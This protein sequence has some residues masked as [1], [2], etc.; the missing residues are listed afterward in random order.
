MELPLKRGEVFHISV[1]KLFV[2]VSLVTYLSN[3]NLTWLY[4]FTKQMTCWPD[5]FQLSRFNLQI[6]KLIMFEASSCNFWGCE[7]CFICEWWVPY[8]M[9]RLYLYLFLGLCLLKTR[10]KHH[11]WT[12]IGLMSWNFSVSRHRESLL[13]AECC[14]NF[15]LCVAKL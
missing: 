6:M 8:W 10:E 11:F 7:S 3:L 14:I 13:L 2:A 5:S 15:K 9:L 4:W 1:S 12:C